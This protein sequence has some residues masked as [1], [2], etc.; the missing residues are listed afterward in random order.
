MIADGYTLSL[1]DSQGRETNER[2]AVFAAAMH[3]LVEH[4]SGSGQDVSINGEAIAQVTRHAWDFAA[5][6]FSPVYGAGGQLV[7]LRRPRS[8]T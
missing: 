8:G 1:I 3:Q 7:E 4:A 5:H 6:G 2:D